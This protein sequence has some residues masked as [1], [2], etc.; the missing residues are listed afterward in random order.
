MVDV[1]VI[2][3]THR[4]LEEMVAEG[5]F[6]E[7]LLFRINTFE[8]AV[9]PL[10]DRLDDLPALVDHFVRRARPQT[11]PQ[12]VAATADTVVILGRHRWPGNVRELANVVEHA[13]VLCDELPLSVGH[14]PA[15][16]IA[17]RPPVV[18]AT[19]AVTPAID[20]PVSLRE[21]ETQAILAALDRHQ[22]NKPRAA[23]ELG[24]SLKTLYNKLAGVA[25]SAAS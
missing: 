25:S 19:G 11:P 22:G 3:A 2:C 10:R 21:L 7:D 16:L 5:T 12:A 20:R 14:L 17:G 13:L 24:I 6:R 18:T 23:E 1:R 8:I 15:R 9:P 4:C